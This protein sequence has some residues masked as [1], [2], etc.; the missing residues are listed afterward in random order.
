MVDLHVHSNYSM[1]AETSSTVRA[2]VEAA[3]SAKMEGIGITD[4][5]HPYIEYSVIDDNR[6][7]LSE[8]L[9]SRVR[10]WIGA[11]IDVTTL[12]GR[13]LGEPDFYR[14]LDYVMAGIHHYHCDWVARPD[15]S[16]D[17]EDVL[18]FV[19]RQIINT[20][21]NP[22]VHVVA[23]PWSG[24]I[25]NLKDFPFTYDLIKSEWIEEL[26]YESIK[27][28]TA[29][30]IPVWALINR[31]GII[32]EPCLKHFVRPLLQTGCFIST[33]T[34]AHQV[35]NIGKGISKLVDIMTQ[36]GAKPQQFWTPDNISR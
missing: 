15:L 5:I 34:D 7:Q 8:L 36:N 27:N 28:G 29:V 1:C 25:K 20:V 30:E 35:K 6:R 18:N 33:G 9:D 21:K 32:N 22:W 23:H 4:H 3:Q 17:S 19:H 16:R 2:I 26:G 12:S 31:E 11:E 13:I 10:V 24:L 14:S